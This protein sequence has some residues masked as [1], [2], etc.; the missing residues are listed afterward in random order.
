MASE[1]GARY[2]YNTLPIASSLRLLKYEQRNSEIQCSLHTVNLA[3]A[4]GF[5]AL[6]YTWG[7]ARPYDFLTGELSRTVTCDGRTL[8]ITQNLHELLC[9]PRIKPHWFLWVDAICINQESL[10][11]RSSQVAMM[12]AIYSRAVNVVVW[13]GHPNIYSNI[14]YELMQQLAPPL[15]ALME[16]GFDVLKHNPDEPAFWNKVGRPPFTDFEQKALIHFFD[17]HWYH[18]CWVI[19]EAIFARSIF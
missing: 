11:E 10:E 5:S 19:Q 4:P 9:A 18:R 14:T 15:L 16:Q 2:V 7:S 6:P 1:S 8:H 12:A 17:R 3:S 13:L